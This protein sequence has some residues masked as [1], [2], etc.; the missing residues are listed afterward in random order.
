MK[1]ISGT[2]RPPFLLQ[3]RLLNEELYR[4]NLSWHEVIPEKIQIQWRIWRKI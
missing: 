4:A 3:G 2:R 1:I